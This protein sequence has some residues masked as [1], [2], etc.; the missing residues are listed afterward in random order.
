MLWGEACTYSL[1]RRTHSGPPDTASGRKWLCP[2]DLI[3]TPPQEAVFDGHNPLPTMARTA[4]TA[5]EKTPSAPPEHD[6]TVL[7]LKGGGALGAYQ[8]GAYEGFAAASTVR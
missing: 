1:V 4:P 5:A 8:A 6:H 7:V 2:R 3:R